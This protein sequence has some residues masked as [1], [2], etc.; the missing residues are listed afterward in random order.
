[1]NIIDIPFLPSSIIYSLNLKGLQ[2][3]SEKKRILLWLGHIRYNM[4]NKDHYHYRL[5]SHQKL[6]CMFSIWWKPIEENISS[7]FDDPNPISYNLYQKVLQH[8]KM[9]KYSFP[10]RVHTLYS[11]KDKTHQNY[12][13]SY[14]NHWQEYRPQLDQNMPF[15][16]ISSIFH[17]PTKHNIHL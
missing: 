9:I 2:Y 5:Y 4:K 15:E 13:K 17:H 1:M 10:H 7:K 16:H 12:P 11:R 8:V 14:N 3:S 6:V